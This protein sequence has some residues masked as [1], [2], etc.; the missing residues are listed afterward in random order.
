MH[1][2][3]IFE[4][5][6][7]GK[8]ETVTINGEPWFVGKDIAEILGYANTQ[9]AIRS[10]VDNEDKLTEQFVRAGQLRSVYIINES[11][12]YSLIFGSKL[13]NA[14]RFKHWVTSVMLQ[15]CYKFR[16]CIDV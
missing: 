5:K 9:K 4:N 2:L 12:L 10:H 6:E 11:G 7:F 3:Q 13:P 16:K 8:I 15:L 14:K 1:E